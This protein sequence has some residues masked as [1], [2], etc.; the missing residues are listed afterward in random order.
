MGYGYSRYK[1]VRIYLEMLRQE[2]EA[3]QQRLQETEYSH[4]SSEE[5]QLYLQNKHMSKPRSCGCGA[6]TMKG[7]C[8]YCGGIRV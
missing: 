1:A 2:K 7:I 8:S 5:R 3:V 4:M 6:L